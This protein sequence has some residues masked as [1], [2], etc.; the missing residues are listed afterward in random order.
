[1]WLKACP[2]CQRGDMY[3]DEDD[4]RHCMHCGYIANTTNPA[5]EMAL[6]WQQ[7]VEDR[8]KPGRAD[9][10]KRP[11]ATAGRPAEES[12]RSLDHLVDLALGG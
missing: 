10:L 9:S 6:R 8:N 3:L 11:A 12:T 5:V 1:M 4:C 7:V 2:R